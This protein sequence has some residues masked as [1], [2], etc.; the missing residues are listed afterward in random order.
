MPNSY[1]LHEDK[2]LNTGNAYVEKIIFSLTKSGAILNAN[3]DFCTISVEKIPSI[4]GTSMYE[5]V[6]EDD[7]LLFIERI[8]ECCDGNLIPF[9]FRFTGSKGIGLP[10]YV[11]VCRWISQNEVLIH[12]IPIVDT[13][14][15]TSVERSLID[16]EI[17]V[18]DITDSAAI[19]MILT[20][21]LLALM[22]L[23]LNSLD[24]Q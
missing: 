5:L 19:N 6:H 14:A 16:K 24:G 10:F 18:F 11:N 23:L 8:F 2:G 13:F 7:R 1:V 9:T 21:L 22:T 4:I 3:K 20:G 15:Y 12:A 17:T